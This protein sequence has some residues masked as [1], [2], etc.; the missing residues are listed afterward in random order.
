MTSWKATSVPRRPTCSWVVCGRKED[1]NHRGTEAQRRKNSRFESCVLLCESPLCVLCASVVR[2]GLFAMAEF[3]P[4]LLKRILKKADVSLDA[5]R[6][7][8][9]YAALNKA[10]QEMSGE[11]VIQVVKDSGLRGR[12]GAGFPCG[13]KWG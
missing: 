2:S 11:Q 1:L 3:E 8:G 12:G 7:D 6:A 13:A 4:V 10:V 5:Y 9:G